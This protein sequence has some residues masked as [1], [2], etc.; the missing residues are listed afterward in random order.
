M[1]EMS[2]IG[3]FFM[4]ESVMNIYFIDKKFGSIIK[5]YRIGLL[6]LYFIYYEFF[7]FKIDSVIYCL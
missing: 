3:F 6:L 7:M 2:Y 5:F 1:M 4:R